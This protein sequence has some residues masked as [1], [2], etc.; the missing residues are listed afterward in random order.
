MER[1][2]DPKKPPADSATSESPAAEE[3]RPPGRYLN[4]GD[5]AVALSDLCNR[6]DAL[7]AAAKNLAQK[8]AF[9]KGVFSQ[10]YDQLGDRVTKSLA[11]S[12]HEAR[13]RKGV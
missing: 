10:V 1:K 11:G 4:P 3:W 7:A 5:M 9:T 12:R 2:A 6:D 8:Q 13:N